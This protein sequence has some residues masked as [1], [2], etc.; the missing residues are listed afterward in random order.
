MGNAKKVRDDV[1]DFSIASRLQ[2]QIRGI[3][4]TKGDVAAATK[5][6]ES[7][8]AVGDTLQGDTLQAVSAE[9]RAPEDFLNRIQAALEEVTRA[10]ERIWE[11]IIESNDNSL[12]A[13]TP[14]CVQKEVD[15]LLRQITEIARQPVMPSGGLLDARVLTAE[16]SKLTFGLPEVN[17]ATLGLDQV[18]PI[19]DP[20]SAVNNHKLAVDA[21]E[22]IRGIVSAVDSFRC[23]IDFDRK[24]VKEVSIAKKMIE[25]ANEDVRRM[26]D[27]LR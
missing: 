18:G 12:P 21:L 24:S 5:L 25:A 13:Q 17:L 11:A 1:L 14:E 16:G 6:V 20:R 27:L 3:E 23:R 10:V 7:Q 26:E 9:A 8:S 15:E 22:I 2:K 19:V 4:K